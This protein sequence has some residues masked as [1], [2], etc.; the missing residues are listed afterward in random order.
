MGNFALA[1]LALGFLIVVHEAGHYF[2]AR[3]CKMRVERFSIGFGPGL[4]KRKAKSGTIFQL[5]PIPF[6]GFV[7]IKG[8]NIAEEV[9]PEDANAYPNRPAWQR[10]LTILAGPAT[11]YLSAIALAF[12]LYMCQ[13][14][15][16]DTY[17]VAEVTPGF[18]AVGKIQP[19]DRILTLDGVSMAGRNLQLSEEIV[20]KQGKP[21]T[22]TVLRDHQVVVVPLTPKPAVDAKGV[23]QRDKHNNLVYRIGI[24]Q[25]AD[26]VDVGVLES[27][28]DAIVYPVVQTKAILKGLYG[29]VFGSEEADPG[30]P[31]RIV[32][33]FKNAFSHG[34]TEGIKLL[35]LLSVYLGLFNLLPLPALDGGRLVFLG[36]EMVTRRRAN[37]KI[38]TMV[39]MVGIMVLMVVMLLVTLH[40]VNVF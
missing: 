25:T 32:S 6:G 7:E 3:W 9:D 1:I 20:K 37:P 39:H 15:A 40:D 18:D 21:V 36:Y 16:G 22:L 19:G 5:A 28:H 30:G 29:I 4:L 35:M 11:N 31:I 33:E 12:G 24:V 10:F 2:V 23:P 14:Q 38:E 27:A 13:G 34:L 8:M 26:F 17:Y